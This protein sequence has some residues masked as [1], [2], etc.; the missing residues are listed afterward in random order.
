MDSRNL[1]IRRAAIRLAPCLRE[2]DLRFTTED[3]EALACDLTRS[4]CVVARLG[5]PLCD[6]IGVAW[7]A[8]SAA[9]ISALGG[10]LEL[11][12][13]MRGPAGLNVNPLLM[14]LCNVGQLRKLKID[15][16]IEPIA[17]TLAL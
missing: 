12:L 7:A 6:N 10:L 8:V 9:R 15:L 13:I 16:F 11:S 1:C 5:L 3:L 14:V 2:L 17:Q 4:T